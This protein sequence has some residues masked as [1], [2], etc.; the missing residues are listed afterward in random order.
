MKRI[1]LMLLTIVLVLSLFAGCAVQDTQQTEDQTPTQTTEQTP[2]QTVGKDT[3]DADTDALGNEVDADVDTENLAIISTAASVTETLFALGCGDQI[4]GVDVYSTYPEET[5]DIEKVGDY[6]GF[7]V[8]KIISLNP[9]VVFAGNSLQS[10]GITALEEAGINVVAVEPTYY[11]DIAESITLI[12]SV[13]GKEDEAAALNEQ[14]SAAAA[15]VEQKA[16]DI[17]D[18]PTVYYVMGIGEYGNWTSG[19]GSFINTVI[20]MAGGV[21]ITAGSESEW[22][23]YPIEDLITAD[24]DILIVSSIV[25]EEDLLAET[26]YSDL[27]AIQNGTYYFINTDI[28]E[29]PGPRITEALETIQGYIIGE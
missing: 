13:V 9:T 24:P 4:V 12:G 2:A 21:C 17:T 16:V 11:D 5:A 15:A 7:D 20:E 18:K 28:I 3:L 27:T 1:L 22:M 25:S 8:E 29:R 23:D 10:Q 6:S 14:M 19:E 26:G